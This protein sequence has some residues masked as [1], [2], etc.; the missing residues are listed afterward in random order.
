MDKRRKYSVEEEEAKQAEFL[1][2]LKEHNG[3]ISYACDATGV[4]RS[5]LARWRRDDVLF[6]G[7]YQDIIEDA[8]DFVE[9]Q[10]FKHMKRGSTGAVIFYLKTKGKHRGYIERSEVDHRPPR[11]GQVDPTKLSNEALAEVLKAHDI[12]EH[13]KK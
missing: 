12:K 9:M 11:V 8:V 10:L 4:T 6:D 2:V 5:I 3:I 1:K 7:A 13:K